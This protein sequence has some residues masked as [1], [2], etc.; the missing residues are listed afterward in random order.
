MI[1]FIE[2]LTV[3]LGIGSVIAIAILLF[4]RV[5]KDGHIRIAFAAASLLFICIAVAGLMT[6]WKS[7][8][9]L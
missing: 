9:Y 2:M 7:V 8:G 1:V 4:S 6:F 5:Q 3:M